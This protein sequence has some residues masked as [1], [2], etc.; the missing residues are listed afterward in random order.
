MMIGLLENQTTIILIERVA[1]KFTEYTEHK[2][3]SSIHSRVQYAQHKVIY[4]CTGMDKL[5]LKHSPCNYAISD[6]YNIH[7]LF[8]SSKSI[9]TDLSGHNNPS[10]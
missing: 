8:L 6:K 9:I 1:H 2:A 10:F 7:F 3:M 4:R 5:M